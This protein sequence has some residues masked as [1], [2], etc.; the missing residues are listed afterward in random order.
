MFQYYSPTPNKMQQLLEL[1]NSQ[2]RY[3]P[4]LNNILPLVT[5][6][7]MYLLAH[8]DLRRT[9]EDLLVSRVNN[10]VL[11][12]FAHVINWTR[13][14]SLAELDPQLVRIAANSADP[15]HLV[16]YQNVPLDILEA[17]WNNWNK[18]LVCRLQFLDEDFIL[19][20]HDTIDWTQLS[21]NVCLTNLSLAT[22]ERFA[23]RLDPT[24]LLSLQ[25]YFT[26]QQLSII[27]P[28]L[29]LLYLN[30]IVVSDEYL[31]QN[32]DMIPT[33]SLLGILLR[34]AF[35]STDF[36]QIIRTCTS[37]TLISGILQY[38]KLMSNPL[39]TIELLIFMARND[40]EL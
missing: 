25:D 29:P 11:V 8:D 17:Q 10:H 22:L 38:V 28:F 39:A 3:N 36:T 31:Y 2:T 37:H 12:R 6:S 19:R 27:I 24:L 1:A 23:P 21:G 34:R 33:T 30:D 14:C 40:L 7:P 13:V 26:S 16:S 32:F 5:V 4:D 15:T 20:H 9:L 35:V 18:S